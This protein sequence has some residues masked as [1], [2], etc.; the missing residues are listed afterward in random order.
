MNAKGNVENLK[1]WKPG[2]SGNPK[3]RPPKEQCV[4]DV[5][6]EMVDV[7]ELCRTL[8]DIAIEKKDVPA[9]KYAIDRLDGKPRETVHNINEEFE[10]VEIDL[11][12]VKTDPGNV[13]IVEE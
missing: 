5:L 12:D 3:G 1:P 7:E 8:I 2:E 4:T 11:R 9:L 10:I 6:R 13:T